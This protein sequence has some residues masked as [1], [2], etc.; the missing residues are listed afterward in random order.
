MLALLRVNPDH[1]PT[2][3]DVPNGMV[4]A[5]PAERAPPTDKQPAAVAGEAAADDPAEDDDVTVG[6][7]QDGVASPGNDEDPDDE[8]PAAN[9]PWSTDAH[10]TELARE[11]QREPPRRS[12]YPHRRWVPTEEDKV[13]MEEVFRHIN[14]PSLS[15]REELSLHLK[16]S[17]R[18]VQVWFQNRRQKEKAITE[19]REGDAKKARVAH[20]GAPPPDDSTTVSIS[21]PLSCAP[22]RHT[23]HIPDPTPLHTLR[24]P[25]APDPSATIMAFR[26]PTHLTLPQRSCHFVSLRT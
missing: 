1:H 25:Y 10:F 23:L 18:K 21:H 20:R 7:E 3:S 19:A 22:R 24:C 14:Y 2:S 9:P 11:H 15:K 26:V 8:T 13:R 5:A 16:V 12:C 6:T 4:A 17:E